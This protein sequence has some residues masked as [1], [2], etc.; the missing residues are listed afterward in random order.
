MFFV[1]GYYEYNH[2]QNVAIGIVNW[3]FQESVFSSQP[4][5]LKGHSFGVRAGWMF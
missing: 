4:S 3:M 1:S 5:I 2:P